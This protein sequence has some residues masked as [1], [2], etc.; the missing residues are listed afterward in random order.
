MQVKHVTAGHSNESEGSSEWVILIAI[1]RREAALTASAIAAR[2]RA[3]V[4]GFRV[5]GLG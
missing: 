5:S 4:R 3:L 1:L 2:S